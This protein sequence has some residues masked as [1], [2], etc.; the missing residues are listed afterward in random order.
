[1][2]TPDAKARIDDNNSRYRFCC[3]HVRIWAMIIGIIEQALLIANLICGIANYTTGRG[4][5]GG[6]YDEPIGI[7]GLVGGILGCVVG[8]IVVGLLIYGLRQERPGF[9]IPHIVAQVCLIL[10]AS[11]VKKSL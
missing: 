6:S 2:K 1:M 8:F 5:Q 3:C 9:L 10:S 11:A 7:S 4:W